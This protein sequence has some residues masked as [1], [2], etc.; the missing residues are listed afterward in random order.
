ME[1]KV[2][3]VCVSCSIGMRLAYSAQTCVLLEILFFVL[4][5]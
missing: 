2:S 4:S 3:M 5:V 1:F